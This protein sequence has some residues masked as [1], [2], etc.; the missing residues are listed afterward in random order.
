[1]NNIKAFKIHENISS[2][3]WPSITSNSNDESFLLEFDDFVNPDS[4]RYIGHLSDKY[5]K[6]HIDKIRPMILLV[7][8]RQLFTK[9]EIYILAQR[10]V[11]ST[12]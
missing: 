7:N 11:T 3:Q 8:K 6:D 12:K 5:I 9:E 4:I 10:L 2:I 1:M